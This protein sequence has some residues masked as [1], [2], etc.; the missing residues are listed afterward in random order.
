MAN[1]FV[2][3]LQDIGAALQLGQNPEAVRQLQERRRLEGMGLDTQGSQLQRIGQILSGQQNNAPVATGEGG[4]LPQSFSNEQLSPQQQMQ[5]LA[6]IGT[7]EAIQALMTIRE[8]QPN[9]VERARVN[10]ANQELSLAQRRQALDERKFEQDQKLAEQRQRNIRN[11]RLGG[12]SPKATDEPIAANVASD[13]ELS[14]GVDELQQQRQRLVP[15]LDDPAVKASTQQQ[16]KAIDEEIK[17]RREIAKAETF[18][19]RALRAQALETGRIDK[20]ID[21]VEEDANM[22]TTGFLG[23]ISSFIG[24]TP[25]SD[26][27]SNLETLQAFAGFD[28]LQQMREQSPTGGALGAV[29]ERELALLTGAIASLQQSQSP[30][31]FRENLKVFRD[32]IRNTWNNVRQAYEQDFGEVPEGLLARF[33]Q[34]EEEV[35]D[36]TSAPQGTTIIDFDAQGNRV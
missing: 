31:Q 22:F 30:E 3:T 10:I 5:Q 19:E 25:A 20:L 17:N 4:T 35:A 6:Q 11:A 23:Q 1:G 21:R 12:K 18:A 34:E 36:S 28:T 2:R 8:Q 15:L 13:A 14:R 29:S 26:L 7:P 32:T 9:A 33:E 27:A 24:G 16:I